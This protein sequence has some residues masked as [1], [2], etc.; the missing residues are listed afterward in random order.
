MKKLLFVIP[1]LIIIYL[2]YQKLRKKN[3][4]L[5]KLNR[6][7]KV[8]IVYSKKQKPSQRTHITS[9]DK[10]AEVLKE[11]WSSQMDF[12]EEFIVLLVDRANKV[13]GYQLISKGGITGTVVDIR[14][15]LAA[16]IKSLASG[17]IIAHNHPSGNLNPSQQDINI[18]RKI[19]EAG[20]TMDV[21]VLDHIIITRDGFYSFADKGRL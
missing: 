15:I 12:R 14:L 9:S 21:K 18:T 16:A 11:I 2:V 10:A 3:T 7:P 17:I 1:T 20:Q 19:K 5:G 6:P 13:L 8:R 4:T